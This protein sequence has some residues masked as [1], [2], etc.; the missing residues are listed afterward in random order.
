L[1]C[2]SFNCKGFKQSADYI[3]EQL[4]SADILCLSETWL[5]PGE[6]HLID[7]VL[8][9]VD[10]ARFGV[11]SKSGMADADPEYKGRP[12]GGFSI[13]YRKSKKCNLFEI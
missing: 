12:Y 6:L 5:R 1:R 2:E 3:T 9:H 13:I 4:K 7:E 10:W 8:S 11:F